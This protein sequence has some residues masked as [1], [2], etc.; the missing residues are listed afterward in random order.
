MIAAN[1]R[2]VRC[3]SS[4]ATATKAED[5]LRECASAGM[6]DITDIQVS[7]DGQESTRSPSRSTL[8]GDPEPGGATTTLIVEPPQIIEPP[9]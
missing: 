8:A 3:A 6:D 1:L 7:I 2:I 9:S 4:P 5:E